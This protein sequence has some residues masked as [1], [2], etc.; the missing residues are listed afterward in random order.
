MGV[1]PRTLWV[2]QPPG[3]ARPI[4]EGHHHYCV[5]GCRAHASTDAA[6]G[7]GVLADP[8]LAR[9]HL[10][11]SGNG[12]SL[13]THGTERACVGQTGHRLDPCHPHLPRLICSEHSGRAC[14]DARRVLA[15]DA[16]RGVRVDHGSSRGF[17][18]A[19]RGVH[20]GADRARRDAF[21]ATSAPGQKRGFV[22]RA[23][24]AVDGQG[25]AAAHPHSALFARRGR[26]R[27]GGRD[28]RDGG[29]RDGGPDRVESVAR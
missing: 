13:R 17:A 28:W 2:L 5:G 15:H 19:W 22:N 10:D 11:R 27:G 8:R 12:A 23:G 21:I 20:D 4:G 26:I 24:R 25:E 14:R 1:P 6:T 29:V 18:E 9:G 3:T 16:R 7:A